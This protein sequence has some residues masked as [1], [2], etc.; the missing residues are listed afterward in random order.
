MSIKSL[1][2]SV[3]RKSTSQP[4]K[5]DWENDLKTTAIQHEELPFIRMSRTVSPSV[6]IGNLP[7]LRDAPPAQCPKLLIR[8][9]RL[10]SYIFKFEDTPDTPQV[11][12]DKEV[13][14][15]TLLELVNYLTVYKPVLSEPE[16]V[17]IFS[18][19]SFNLFRPFQRSTLEQF[20]MG[21][22]P[23][24]DEPH[25]EPT[26]PHLQVVYE[27]LLRLATSQETDQALLSKFFNP[28]FISNIL[29]LFD[30]EDP[31]ER[32]YLKTILHRIYGNF[33]SL[34][35]YIRRVINDAFYRFIYETDRHNGIPELLEILGSI[36]NGFALPLKDQHK[37]MLKQV[38]LPLHKA[39]FLSAFHPQLSYCITQFLEKDPTL[40][41]NIVSGV[42]KYWPVTSSKK[43]L[44]FVTE[45][46]EILERVQP[47]HLGASMVPLFSRLA[48]CINGGHFQVSERAIS[49]LNND[50]LLRFV[51][52]NKKD[53][54]PILC[55]ALLSNTYNVPGRVNACKDMQ[56]ELVRENSQDWRNRP[57][58][59]IQR[60]QEM[61]HWNAA[62]VDL[63]NELLRQLAELDVALMDKCKRSYEAS[64]KQTTADRKKRRSAWE[65]IDKACAD[66]GYDTA[67]AEAIGQFRGGLPQSAPGAHH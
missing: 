47:Q 6:V 31:R 14:R 24:E 45:L 5:S 7:M 46:E 39:S 29:V 66:R 2:A 18:M 17:E 61:G 49:V 28:Q 9:L 44:M 57:R 56:L 23:D 35:P 15:A 60:W 43:E 59:N 42:L 62:V 50:V 63:T 53:L 10:C 12:K 52:P 37:V 13:K 19:L 51:T 64:V 3:Q 11:A 25:S 36:I 27:F 22:S 20:G 54:M 67:K 48:A 4:T 8:K 32:D 33:M 34:R 40:A 58:K 38:L 21:Y 16:L 1:M 55:K 41:P 26:W 65:Q 30:S